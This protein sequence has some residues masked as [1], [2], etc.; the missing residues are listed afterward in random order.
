M[1]PCSNLGNGSLQ[2][3]LD[4]GHTESGESGDAATFDL[5]SVSASLR[6]IDKGSLSA[7]FLPGR[8]SATVKHFRTTAAARGWQSTAS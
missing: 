4:A 6:L 7:A 8:S 2:A 3:Q 1:V 5:D